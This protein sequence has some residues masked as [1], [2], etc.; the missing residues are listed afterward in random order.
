[1]NDGYVPTPLASTAR[2]RLSFGMGD[3]PDSTLDVS[4][5]WYAKNIH[6]LLN[7]VV[8]I[9]DPRYVKQRFAQWKDTSPTMR[10][11]W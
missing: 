7:E 6:Y 1:M 10:W 3:G 4:T 11:C 9:E 5:Q 2:A 8:A